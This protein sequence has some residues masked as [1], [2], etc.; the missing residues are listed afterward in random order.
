M[1]SVV[2]EATR[3]HR[4]SCSTL[5]EEVLGDQRGLVAVRVNLEAARAQVSSDESL[6]DVDAVRSPTTELGYGAS[7]AEVRSGP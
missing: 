4:A 1:T 6:T 5:I 2:L 7:V 3:M